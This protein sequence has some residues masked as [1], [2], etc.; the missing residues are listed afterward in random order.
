MPKRVS[1][2]ISENIEPPGWFAMLNTGPSNCFD[3]TGYGVTPEAALKR[4]IK[5][6]TQREHAYGE[7][8][9]ME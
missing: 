6:I 2:I 5:Q 8:P 3:I 9:A 1:Y 7:K 4:L